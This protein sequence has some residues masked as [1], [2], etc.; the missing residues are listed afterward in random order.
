[1]VFP[2]QYPQPSQNHQKRKTP[3][4]G[5]FLNPR[6]SHTAAPTPKSP[7]SKL[8]P[9]PDSTR[10]L[11]GLHGTNSQPDPVR[12]SFNP[13]PTLSSSKLFNHPNGLEIT[14]GKESNP[15]LVN[16][17]AEICGVAGGSARR[18]KLECGAS[19]PVELRLIAVALPE[20]AIGEEFL[21]V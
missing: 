9:E 11:V 7:S 2:L 17:A 5:F 3:P 16:T 10:F 4:H 1:V 13:L 21:R 6:N 15:I 8:R 18:S 20:D 12:T 14:R 19:N